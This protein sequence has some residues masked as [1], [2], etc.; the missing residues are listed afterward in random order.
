MCHTARGM[1]WLIPLDHETEQHGEHALPTHRLELRQDLEPGPGLLRLGPHL[2]CLLLE[3]LRPADHA[4]PLPLVLS[5]LVGDLL[6]LVQRPPLL[7][8]LA[9]PLDV[10]LARLLRLGLL[11]PLQASG[12]GAKRGRLLPPGDLGFCMARA[13]SAFGELGRYVAG[14]GVN[15][16][17]REEY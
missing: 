6:L 8:P 12:L 7:G 17:A 10:R 11:L 1:P 13:L 16:H 14:L 9:R 2:L 15:W 4:Q 5:G 3:L